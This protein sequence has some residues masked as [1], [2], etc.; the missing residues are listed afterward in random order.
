MIQHF[1]FTKVQD[2][3]EVKC[4][5]AVMHNCKNDAKVLIRKMTRGYACNDLLSVA[6]MPNRFEKTVV[7]DPRD[8][9]DAAEGLRK[10]DARVLAAYNASREKAVRRYIKACKA[11]MGS[12]DESAIPMAAVRKEKSEG[13]WY[14]KLADKLTTK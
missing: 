2:G 9:F 6:S 11:A 5:R 4:V 3:V 12:L 10:A 1:I 14:E 7:C 8:E 13:D